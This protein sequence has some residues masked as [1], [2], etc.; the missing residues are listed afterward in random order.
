MKKFLIM[1]VAVLLL[2]CACATAQP[3]KITPD[4]SMATPITGAAT[5]RKLETVKA[6][7]LQSQPDPKSA[8]VGQ[9]APGAKGKVLGLNEKGTWVLVQFPEQTGW[10]PAVML[11][12]VLAQ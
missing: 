10:A 5:V 2:L 12:L 1:A 4:A 8:M 9:V 6:L 7:V 11:D 3:V